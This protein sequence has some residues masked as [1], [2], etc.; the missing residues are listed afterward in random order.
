MYK[1]RIVEI[2]DLNDNLSN[3]KFDMRGEHIYCVG[4][5]FINKLINLPDEEFPI[6]KHLAIPKILNFLYWVDMY[7]RQNDVTLFEI[8]KLTF[9]DFFTT[10]EYLK[11]VT[12]LRNIEVMSSIKHDNGMMYSKELGLQRQYRFHKNYTNDIPCLFFIESNKKFT[13]HNEIDI[14]NK[15]YV[16][17][18]KEADISI[19]SCIKD[20]YDYCMKEK[21]AFSLRCRIGNVLA[22]SRQ[23]KIK[24]GKKVR[25]IY[26]S[27][28]N[29]SHISR[30]YLKVDNCS[31]VSI[32]IKNAQPLLL[33]YY[34]A[35]NNYEYDEQYLLECEKGTLYENFITKERSRDKVKVLLYKNVYYAFRET[36][37]IATEFKALFPK[38]FN[39]LKYITEALKNENLKLAGEMQNLEADIFNHIVPKKSKYYF[40]LFDS[41]Y[42]TD[43]NDMRF[44]QEELLN[45]FKKYNITPKFSIT[46]K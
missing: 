19:V 46:D 8:G 33:V 32:D 35:S 28:S 27:F 34:M 44:I 20:E 39:S 41:I 14:L 5:K 25:R 30:K 40:T 7:I 11:Y 45:S 18:I 23:R 21:S 42:F 4:Y 3:E 31:F 13:F 17:T 26:H 16:D 12:L 29:L 22:L 10:K 6:A 24:Y 37:E 15:K 9:V 36:S 43:I 38:T 2:D 1:Y